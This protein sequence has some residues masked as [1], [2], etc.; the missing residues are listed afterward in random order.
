MI[1]PSKPLSTSVLAFGFL[2][3]YIPIISLVVYSFNESKLVT[4]WSGFSL[5]WYAALLD[6]D[7]LLTAAWLSLKIGLLTATASVV[8]GTWAGFVLAR[9]GRFKGF[10]LYTGMI[11]APLVIPEVIQGISLL[12]LFVALEQMFGWPKGRG[13]VTIW[14]GHVMLCVSYVAIIVQSR[15]KEMNKSLEEA[16]YDLGETR[17]SAFRLVTLPL[18]MPGIISSLLISFTISLDEFI[19]AF[20]LA[21]NQPTLPTY[22]FSQLRFPKQIPMIMALGTVLVALSIVLLALGEYFRRRGNARMGGNPT[23]GFL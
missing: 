15:V 5:K 16:A 7:E 4:V 2:F 21:G 22:I 23:G 18:V 19:I 6:D 12:L 3:L 14:I 10:T 13:M 11:N 1:K 8:I 9:F 17:W 20:F